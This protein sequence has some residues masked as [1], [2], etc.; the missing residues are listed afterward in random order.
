M[1]LL[2]LQTPAEQIATWVGEATEMLERAAAAART[3]DVVPE[4]EKLPESFAAA[5]VNGGLTLAA[6]LDGTSG[7]DSSLADLRRYADDFARL[8]ERLTVNPD[9]FSVMQA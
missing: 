7:S 3:F 6:D 4:L 8:V 2:E 5:I 9:A 1:S